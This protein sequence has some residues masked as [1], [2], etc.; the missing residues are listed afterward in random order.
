MKNVL[1]A[2]CTVILMAS[3]SINQNVQGPVTDHQRVV[4][5]VSNSTPFSIRDYFRQ[6]RFNPSAIYGDV[7]T[8]KS[9][10]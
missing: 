10:N 2:F 1:F 5:T 8:N 9:W 3:C 4:A 7:F 6:Y